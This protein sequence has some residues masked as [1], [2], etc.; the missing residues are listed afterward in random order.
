MK[1]RNSVNTVAL[2]ALTLSSLSSTAYS[3]SLFGNRSSESLQ[4]VEQPTDPQRPAVTEA[5]AP[6]ELKAILK[7]KG[8]SQADEDGASADFKDMRGREQIRAARTYALQKGVEWRYKQINALLQTE[9]AKLDAAFDFKRL[10]MSGGMLLPPVIDEAKESL[11]IETPDYAIAADRTFNILKDARIIGGS[12]SWRDYLLHQ[13]PVSKELNPAILPR[14]ESEQKRWAQAALEGW[15]D[16]I[17][18]ANTLHEIAVNRLKRDF[19]GMLKYRELV[20][21]GVVSEPVLAEGRIGIMVDGKRLEVG[22][23][24]FRITVP[25]DFQR[26]DR[27]RAVVADPTSP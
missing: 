9:S 12:P 14:N 23:K 11:N 25:A 22:R 8:R 7:M 16:G 19:T 20:A 27:W 13:Y 4:S 1:T 26:T 10:I 2:I 15:A 5:N 17:E 24:T 21:M 6:A 3:A 18:Q